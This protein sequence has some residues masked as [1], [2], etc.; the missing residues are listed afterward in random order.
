[1]VRNNLNYYDLKAAEWWKPNG[2][3]SSLKALNTPRFEFFDRYVQNWNG[4]KVL[5]VGCGGGYTS[6]FLAKRGAI[7]SGLDLS[8]KSI[9]AASWHASQTGL[10]IDYLQ[11]SAE[12]IPFEDNSFDAAVCVDV[13]EH[14]NDLRQVILEIYRI[15]KQ[16]SMFFFDTINRTFKSKI[17]VIWLMEIILRD[18]PRGTHDWKKF[19]KPEE[20]RE[21]MIWEGLDS[22]EIKG[23]DVRGKDRKSGQF[24][25]QINDNSSIMYIGKAVKPAGPSPI[26]GK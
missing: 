19:I 23:L 1:M 14:I 9:E 26:L 10:R 12:A 17:A 18:M 15:L 21:V 11:G 2:E 16:N 20:L 4:L 8:R 3:F 7:V 22:I 13:L 24:N 5:D 25:I 6:E